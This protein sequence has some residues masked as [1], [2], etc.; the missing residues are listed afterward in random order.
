MELLPVEAAE[1]GG[2]LAPSSVDVTDAARLV[3]PLSLSDIV[4]APSPE[5]PC[6]N[7][8]KHEG[9]AGGRGGREG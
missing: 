9:V 1:G 4:G 3:L 8:G 5:R 7:P 6:E 2:G